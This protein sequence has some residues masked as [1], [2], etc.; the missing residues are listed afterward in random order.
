MHGK[1]LYGYGGNPQGHTSLLTKPSQK[2]G[3]P[4]Y[5]HIRAEVLPV[6]LLLSLLPVWRSGLR[7]GLNFWQWIWNHTVFGPPIE[8]IPQEDYITALTK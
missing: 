6:V 8:Y 2:P 1:D 3:Q 4:T 5:L 7:D